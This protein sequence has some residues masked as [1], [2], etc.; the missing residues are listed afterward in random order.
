MRGWRWVGCCFAL[1]RGGTSGDRSSA[2]PPPPPGG[3]GG[4][5]NLIPWAGSLRSLPPHSNYDRPC[6]EPGTP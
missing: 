5:E 1:Y 6:C 3:G 4:G 2:P